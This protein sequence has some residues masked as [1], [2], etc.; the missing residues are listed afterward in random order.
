MGAVFEE[1]SWRIRNNNTVEDILEKQNIV[2]FIKA[3]RIRWL[4]YLQRMDKE[5]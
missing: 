3:G 4:D 2:R 1:G 5:I